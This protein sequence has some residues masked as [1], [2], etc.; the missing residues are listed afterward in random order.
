MITLWTEQIRILQKQLAKIKKMWKNKRKM[1]QNPKD[2]K[3][4]ETINCQT[5]QKTQGR[6]KKYSTWH[7]GGHWREQ[8]NWKCESRSQ[9]IEAG[10]TLSTATCCLS[11]I[12]HPGNSGFP[13]Q[14]LRLAHHVA[15]DRLLGFNWAL[16]AQ[17]DRTFIPRVSWLCG[18]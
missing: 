12:H 7:P 4:V 13:S 18:L 16:L 9:D 15:R 17:K 3:K 2:V 14:P 6:T 1:S 8:F 10:Q 11:K 5:P